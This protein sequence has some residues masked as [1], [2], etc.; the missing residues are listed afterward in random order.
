MD[1]FPTNNRITAKA[2]VWA[3]VILITSLAF[4]YVVDLFFQIAIEEA[5]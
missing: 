3:A 4:I 2:F 1:R 5:K